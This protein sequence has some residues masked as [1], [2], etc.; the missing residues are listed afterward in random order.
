MKSVLFIVAPISKYHR[1]NSRI[2]MEFKLENLKEDLSVRIT[3][4]PMSEIRCQM[5]WVEFTAANVLSMTIN[6]LRSILF[7]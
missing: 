7:L 1:T 3:F 4:K 6:P 2:L 5:M